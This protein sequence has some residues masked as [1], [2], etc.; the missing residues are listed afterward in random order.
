MALEIKNSMSN[1]KDVRTT[2]QTERTGKRV[3]P[4]KDLYFNCLKYVSY[5]SIIDFNGSTGPQI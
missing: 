3:E 4:V 5:L 1:I 2:L